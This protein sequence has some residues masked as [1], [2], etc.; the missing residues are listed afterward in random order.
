MPAW[1]AKLNRPVLALVAVGAIAGVLRFNELSFPQRRVFDE[2]YYPK[3]A[4]IFLGYSNERCDINSSDERFWREDKLDTGAWVHPPLG[5]WTIAA[6][7]LLFGT[8]PFGW[9]FSSALFGTATVVLL[10]LIAQLLFASA[11]WTFVTGLLLAV[12]NLSFVQSRI[13]TLDVFVAFWV[14]LGFLF[15]L[16]DRR[17]IEK[18]DPPPP[19]RIAERP[20]VR[21]PI[22]RPWRFAAGAA[23]GAGVATKWSV[24]AAVLG[25]VT[26][27]AIW[28]V[29]RRRRAGLTRPVADAI[30]AEGFGLVLAYLLVP[31]VVY[32]A[33]YVGWFAHFGWDLG[34]WARLQGAIASYH[35]G[36]R[37]ID[38]ATGE[39]VHGY[40]SPAWQWLLLWRPTFYF[41]VYGDAVRRVIYANG[42]PVIF[43]AS[44]LAIPYTAF[45][46]W[47]HRDWRAGFVVVAIAS[48]Y[49]P[50]FLIA[51]PRFFFYV[52]PIV[53]F[54][55]LADVFAI[56]RLSE[57]RLESL[58]PSSS[59][60]PRAVRPYVPVAVGFV[61]LAV[62]LFA[63]FWP[64]MTGGSLSDAD[65]VRRRWFSTW[66]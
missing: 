39:P 41:G 8:D 15:V 2:Y 62:V 7:E 61:V 9:R 40:L 26:L 5:K 36:L 58:R 54:L 56:R 48:Q 30:P 22:W 14:V 21:A 13:A 28:E 38:P 49:L 32:L 44:L 63:W 35:E 33:S 42:N 45:V 23:L 46:W 59:L 27:G 20:R 19:H 37:T 43:W 29:A 66:T 17:W 6:G 64:V 24:L 1:L 60:R 50:W 55:V 34:E 53:P 25:A 51:R 12:E 52:T 31:A 57:T 47:R 3:S 16:M 18:R 4:C 11:L 10:A 65:W